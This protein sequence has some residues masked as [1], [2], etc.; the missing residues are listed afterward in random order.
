M[1]KQKHATLV[2]RVKVQKTAFSCVKLGVFRCALYEG[3]F[4]ARQYFAHRFLGTFLT[5]R[6][7]NIEMI[8]FVSRCLKHMFARERANARSHPKIRNRGFLI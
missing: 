4:N 2:S 7:L 5:L 3:H 6:T 8:F 1:Q